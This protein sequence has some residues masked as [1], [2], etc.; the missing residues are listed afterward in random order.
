MRRSG[1]E[2]SGVGCY[3][4]G[5]AVQPSHFS[6]RIIIKK[7]RLRAGGRGGGRANERARLQ[8][9]RDNRNEIRRVQ[10]AARF[11]KCKNKTYK[12]IKVM[13]ETFQTGQNGQHATGC[14]TFDRKTVSEMKRSVAA[15]P[16]H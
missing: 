3:P 16:R 12:K 1:A 13:M 2:W 4:E 11:Q 5:S 7:L 10:E 6:Q 8:S 14:R 15:S 9:R